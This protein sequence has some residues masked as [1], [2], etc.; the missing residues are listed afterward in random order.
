MGTIQN[1]ILVHND[2]VVMLDEILMEAKQST[3]LKN[4]LP[5]MESKAYDISF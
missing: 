1:L 3:H 5:R 4:H 2:L